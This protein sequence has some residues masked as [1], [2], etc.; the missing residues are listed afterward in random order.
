MRS[1]DFYS[2]SGCRDLLFHVQETR[3]S[4]A[5]ID[6]FLRTEGLRF[7]GFILPD[8]VMADYRR[9]FPQDVAATD[10]ACWAIYEQEN[11]SVFAAMYQ[12][13]VQNGRPAA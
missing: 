8:A 11:P 13:W 5:E 3:F 4:L 1:A 12:F 10:L 6:R 9:R 7:L 2:L